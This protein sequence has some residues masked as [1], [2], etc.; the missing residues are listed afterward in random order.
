MSIPIKVL[1]LDDV[2]I[3][4]GA[5]I[6]EL[7]R[8]GYDTT[9][10][11]VVTREAMLM[12]LDDEDWDIITSD[13]DMPF[14][15]A[16][17]ALKVLKES[18]REIPFIVVSGMISM[19]RAIPLVK[20]G[21]YDFVGK[22]EISRLVP[23]VERALKQAAGVKERR[24]AAEALRE[25]EER[26]RG[27]VETSNDLIWSADADGNWTF[28]NRKAVESIFG[29]EPEEMIGRPVTELA[30]K[31]RVKD[32]TDAFAA[33][34][35][36]SESVDYDT[37]YVNKDGSAVHMNFK[38]MPIRD[39]EGNIVGITGTARDMTAR[40]KAEEEL[41]K[42]R[43][44]LEI[45]VEERTKDL[46]AE[47]AERKKA[48]EQ[49]RLAAQVIY[50]TSEAV[51]ITDAEFRITA[52]N[53][54][55]TKITGYTED[56]IVGKIPHLDDSIGGDDPLYSQMWRAIEEHEHW[57]GEFW[58]KRKNGEDYAVRASISTITDEDGAVMQY[59][60]LISD[61]TERKVA[62]EKVRYQANYDE[63]TGLPNRS[64]FLDQLG[65]SL[66]RMDRTKKDMALMFIDLDR[67]KWVNDTLGHD[68]GDDL[69]CQ[70]AARMK[71]C[72]RRVDTVARLGGDEF[73]IILQE[74]SKAEDTVDIAEKVIEQISRS[75]TLG[76]KEAS[77]GASI[78]ITVAP[79]DGKDSNTLLRNADLAMY[80]AKKAGRSTYK[81]FTPE[82]NDQA[83]SRA[84]MET[85][86][87]QA[88]DEDE[89]VVYYQPIADL[90]SG[91]VSYA[92]ALVRWNHPQRGLVF[93]DEFISLAEETGLIVGIGE[94]VLRSACAQAKAWQD[95]GQQHG[96]SVSVNLSS[97]QLQQ[98]LSIETVASIL[99][100]T[101]LP[102]ERLTFEITESQIM[103]DADQAI[104]WLN[105]I[106]K[107]GVRLSIDDFGTG[108][109]SLSYLKRFPIDTLKIDRSFIRDMTTDPDDAS[110][111]EAITA[112]AR[113]LKLKVIA[114]GVETKEQLDQ[115]RA[116][117]CDLIQGYFFSKALSAEEFGSLLEKGDE[118]WRLRLARQRLETVS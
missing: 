21:A 31:A 114:E 105:A 80:A 75:F 87:R 73:V 5:L 65:Q 7:N 44:E 98:G 3:D 35:G 103:E 84:N 111:V 118:V 85:E 90:E 53:P 26:Y 43:D 30:D 92:E 63:L 47:I 46:T 20:A 106:K 97:R 58:N 41:R 2:E 112:M 116:L 81:F 42:A 48:E 16:D 27:L 69:L 49:L 37:V 54:A 102:A 107:M 99:S 94:W 8:G 34:R 60:A 109:S 9:W 11:R 59:A 10:R 19:G 100:E 6:S 57:E 56:D 66:N 93:P 22:L 51:L 23:S 96:F 95:K 101:G 29:Y 77:I 68:A 89:L 78:G 55:F 28:V 1:I 72:I 115:L 110:L 117:G 18:G 52:I 108:Y 17:D 88:L 67:F 36:G 40:I 33:I 25:N 14:F 83:L 82:M 70:V 62:E 32:G 38:A 86:L 91:R 74:I 104:I 24:A 76:R 71:E 64:L 39:E 61:I 50:A 13:Y 79:V 15:T 113:S 4:A 45:R 12:A